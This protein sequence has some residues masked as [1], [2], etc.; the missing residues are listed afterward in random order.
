MSRYQNI[1]RE[2][3]TVEYLN[4]FVVVSVHDMVVK[5]DAQIRA[6]IA[7]MKESGIPI[8]ACKEFSQKHYEETNKH[9]FQ[10]I[11]DTIIDKHIRIIK[12]YLV[13][14]AN[15]Y[16]HATG[17]SIDIRGLL[18]Y[19]DSSLSAN[20]TAPLT[21]RNNGVNDYRVQCAAVCDFTDFLVQQTEEL[22]A[23]LQGY[24]NCCNGLLSCGVP[25][26][27][28]DNYVENYAKP[29]YKAIDNNLRAA[30]IDAY[31]YLIK[32]YN[33]IVAS[34]R[35]IGLSVARAPRELSTSCYGGESRAGATMT[36]GNVVQAPHGPGNKAEQAKEQNIRDLERYLGIK[37]GPEMSIAQADKQNANPHFGEGPEYSINCA[38]CALTYVLR[39]CLGFN[40]IAKGNDRSSDSLNYWLSD[41]DNTFKVWKNLDGKPVQPTYMRQ[42][43]EKNSVVK[44]EAEDYKRF[45]DETC[46]DKGVYILLLSWNGGGG[47]ATILERDED[48]VLY[49]IEP[50]CFKAKLSDE[51]GRRDVDDLV[52]DKG[53]NRLLQVPLDCDG[54]LKIDPDRTILDCEEQSFFQ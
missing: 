13:D 20:A 33:S 5:I 52:Y 40:V 8:E 15:Q 30:L 38:T 18:V 50:Q 28:C 25:K 21:T 47:H 37:R 36:T 48:G 3:E 17:T 4:R 9:L 45:F 51:D 22:N 11:C 39:R 19:P 6:G 14:L 41:N 46:K 49:Y 29:L 42:W 12:Q 32:V 53:K 23:V 31:Q 1:H 43:M 44:M 7:S 34:M 26:Q 2:I 10:G 35:N 27:V 16:F 54:I 24:G